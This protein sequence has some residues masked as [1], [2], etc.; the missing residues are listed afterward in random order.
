MR[1]NK[2]SRKQM[3]TIFKKQFLGVTKAGKKCTIENEDELYFTYDNDKFLLKAFADKPLIINNPF[4][5]YKIY[6]DINSF[7]AKFYKYSIKNADIYSSIYIGTSRFEETSNSTKII[8]NR[9]KAFNG[10]LLQFFRNFANMS[11]G[12]DKFV[13]FYKSFQDN[14]KNYFTVNST[15]G[16]GAQV[17][18]FPQERELKPKGFVAEFGFLYN[19]KEQ[20]KITF[21][22]DNFEIDEFGLFTNYDKIYFSGALS[23]K[24]VG[25]MLP[26]NYGIK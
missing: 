15:S 26:S 25:L 22:T 24:K 10:S 4:L 20:S 3:M 14:P 9:E 5:G 13:L 8:R 23:E 16:N 12:K 11:W 7:E 21:H 6:F 19:N 18:I 2:F 17:T 1:N